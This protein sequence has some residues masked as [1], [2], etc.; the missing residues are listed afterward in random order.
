MRKKITIFLFLV[1]TLL[2]APHLTQAASVLGI[3]GSILAIVLSPVIA[4]F[5]LITRLFFVWSA[6]VLVWVANPSFIKVSFTRNEFVQEGWT[7]TRDFT[8]MFFLLILVAIGFAT[9]LRIKGYEVSKTLP[10]LIGVALLINFTPVI[11]GVV[12][13]AS[14]IFMNFF[15]SAGGAGYSGII[16]TITDLAKNVADALYTSSARNLLNGQLLFQGLGIILFNIMGAFVMILMAG[17]FLIRYMA[18]W[19]LV[20]LSPL[21]FAALILPSTQ[22]YWGIWWK[23]F[24]NWCFVGVGASFFLYL[25]QKMAE[26]VHSYIAVPPTESTAL[27]L[28][29]VRFLPLIFLVIGFFAT[30]NASAMG[31]SQTLN[32]MKKQIG[33]ARKK[34]IEPRTKDFLRAYQEKVLG[35]PKVRQAMQK[36]QT[37]RPPQKFGKAGKVLAPATWTIRKLSQG[38]SYVT[39]TPESTLAYFTRD[40]KGLESSSYPALV[41]TLTASGATVPLSKKLAALSILQERGQL[42]EAIKNGLISPEQ[43]L[44]ILSGIYKHRALSKKHKKVIE[45]LERSLYLQTKDQKQRDNILARIVRNRAAGEGK[46]V[47]EWEA[48]NIK[49]KGYRDYEQIILTSLKTPEDIESFAGK[50]KEGMVEKFLEKASPSQVR[51][52]A[53]NLGNEFNNLYSKILN[54][55]GAAWL[56]EIDSNTNN[57]RNLPLLKY[58]VSTAAQAYLPTPHKFEETAVNFVVKKAQEY[59]SKIRGAGKNTSQLKSLLTNLERE[60][61]SILSNP[62]LTDEQ[63]GIYESFFDSYGKAIRDLIRSQQTETDSGGTRYGDGSGGGGR[64]PQ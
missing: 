26:F 33:R 22:K 41:S 43:V 57:P 9:A 48:E 2:F 17:L 45:G 12:I 24:L 51:K 21:G 49:G 10:R 56:A 37:L 5:T 8:Y 44:N 61:N 38:T 16:N 3:L 32:F 30:T 63:K 36:L 40:K 31:A 11:C 29:L 6:T 60:K 52:W 39:G 53:E 64:Y 19:T 28:L 59:S 34:I 35:R 50:L 20:I 23:Q 14:N 1:L 15:L 47:E 13:D 7:I 27:G 42:K 46:T 4:V 62:K 55:K 18:L 25:S 54:E 58:A